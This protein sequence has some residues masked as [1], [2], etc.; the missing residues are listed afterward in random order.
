MN[1][2]L[3]R[4]VKGHVTHS[5]QHQEWNSSTFA[6]L[7]LQL[8]LS[9]CQARRPTAIHPVGASRRRPVKTVTASSLGE[10]G[11]RD[12]SRGVIVITHGHWCHQKYNARFVVVWK[13]STA[14]WW[15]MMPLISCQNAPHGPPLLCMCIKLSPTHK[16]DCASV[17]A[18]GLDPQQYIGLHNQKH[19]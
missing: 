17:P 3:T 5:P 1:E 14:T 18:L 10:S 4:V 13:L 19:I 15:P 11:G 2:K 8:C 7:S 16:Q 6:V 12:Q 9:L